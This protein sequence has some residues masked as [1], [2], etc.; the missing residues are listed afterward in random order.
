MMIILII[1]WF[2]IRSSSS[3]TI[4]IIIISR[5]IIGHTPYVIYDLA[6]QWVKAEQKKATMTKIPLTHTRDERVS[7]I[8]F[9]HSFEFD[10]KKHTTQCDTHQSINRLSWASYHQKAHKMKQKKRTSLPTLLNDRN[11]QSSGNDLIDFRE[12]FF[13]FF[14]SLH[15]SS[16]LGS[17]RIVV[18]WQWSFFP[19]LSIAAAFLRIERTIFDSCSLFTYFQYDYQPDVLSI[20]N[21]EM[22]ISAHRIYET[23]HYAVGRVFFLFSYQTYPSNTDWYAPWI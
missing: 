21:P 4:S 10:D 3:I 18:S 2:G 22:K 1:I 9:F 6:E 15:P 7:H 17:C 16:P 5:A 20:L 8:T 11:I 14:F 12:R 19:V 23:A 13:L